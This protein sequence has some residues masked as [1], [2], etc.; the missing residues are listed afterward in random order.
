[1][2]CSVHPWLDDQTLSPADHPAPR[3]GN[4]NPPTAETP[5]TCFS[6]PSA[7]TASSTC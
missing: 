2:Q 7:G 3:T 5:Q 1:M 6:A 4:L